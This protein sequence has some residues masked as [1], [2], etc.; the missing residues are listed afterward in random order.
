[1]EEPWKWYTTEKRINDAI[2]QTVESAKQAGQTPKDDVM[3]RWAEQRLAE[4]EKTGRLI[5]ERQWADLREERFLKEG[6]R[7][8]Y[9]GPTRSETTSSGKQVTRPNGQEGTIIGALKTPGGIQVTFQPDHPPAVVDTV[10]SDVELV[11]LEVMAITP[12]YFTLERLP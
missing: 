1:M 9:V 4:A 10:K 2:K 8:K 6:D 12:G 7:A 11:R 3:A 5:S